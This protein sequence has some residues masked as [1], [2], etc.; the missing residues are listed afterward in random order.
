MLHPVFKLLIRKPELVMEHLA[1]YGSLVH[2]EVSDVGVQLGTRL[3]AWG[4]MVVMASVFVTLTGVAV[5]IGFSTGAFHWALLVVPL[6]ALLAT[7]GC[8]LYARTPMPAT[9]FD[10]LKAQIDAD[11][12]A[13]RIAGENR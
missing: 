2:E 11:V 5:M 13:L 1:G 7:L 9:R 6:I 4:A 3:A 12:Q 10:S 8:Y